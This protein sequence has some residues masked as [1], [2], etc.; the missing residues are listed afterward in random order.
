MSKSISSK[1][2]WMPW[3]VCLSGGLFFFYEFVQV[4]MFNSISKALMQEFNLNAQQLGYLSATYFYAD[5]LFLF[6]AGMILDRISTRWAIIGGLTLCIFSTVG[7]ALSKT[8]LMA[9]IFHFIVG[10]ASAFCFPSCIILTSRW[11]EPKKMASAIG[12]IVTMA[13]LGGVVAQTPFTLLNNL[14]GWRITLLID[15]GLGLLI[16]FIIILFVYDYPVYAKKYYL[17]IRHQL[18]KMG[19]LESVWKVFSNRQNWYCA[20]YTN[21]LNLPLMLLGGLWGNLY[22]TEARNQSS[23]SAA[24][25]S[26]M[27]FVGTIIGAPLVGYI[28][29]RLGLRKPPMIF[30]GFLSLILILILMYSPHLT[31]IALLLIFLGL[32]I[33]TSTQVIS[34]PT[35]AENNIYELTGT[36]TGFTSMIIMSGVAIFEPFFGWLMEFNHQDY[37]EI[38]KSIYMVSDFLHALWIFPITLFIGILFSF[39][40]QETFCRNKSSSFFL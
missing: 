29:D 32:G 28:S 22:L 5:V 18:R 4:H 39:L 2:T 20:L 3:I 11:F 38:G 9:G 17:T 14:F 23:I 31:T 21:F 12:L 24:N 37:M 33:F 25:I 19:G 40:I 7:F 16:L 27:I 6:P 8:A 15:A 13:M 30:G 35:I 10:I 1:Q 26:S 34:Y 36:A